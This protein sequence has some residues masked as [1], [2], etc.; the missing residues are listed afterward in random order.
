MSRREIRLS[1][2]GGQGIILGG[3]ILAEAAVQDGKEVVQT[4]SYGPEARGGASKAEIIISESPIL[5]PKV[6]VPNCLL[7]LSQEAAQLYGASI[8]QDGIIVVDSNIVKV[9]PE[10]S[11]RIIPLPLSQIAREEIGHELTTNIVA[12]GAL[13]RAGGI[14]SL[15]AL[16]EAVRK[17]LAKV[18][19]IN[20]KALRFGWERAM[21]LMES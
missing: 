19:N 10:V 9:M 14:V 17:R 13:A 16:E 6:V 20:I 11:A 1:G 12:I 21:A 18:A 7:L 4:Q 2:T 5:Y 3:I 15:E 8:G